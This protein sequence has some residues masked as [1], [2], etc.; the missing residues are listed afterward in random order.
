MCNFGLFSEPGQTFVFPC[1]LCLAV[2]SFVEWSVFKGVSP[3]FYFQ[4]KKHWKFFGRPSISGSN[5]LLWAM[6]LHLDYLKLNYKGTYIVWILVTILL[7][8]T[9]VLYIF[10]NL[11]TEKLQIIAHL[12]KLEDWD[13]LLWELVLRTHLLLQ[14]DFFFKVELSSWWSVSLACLIAVVDVVEV[15]GASFQKRAWLADLSY[16]PSL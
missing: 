6:A 10:K 15:L 4:K 16:W 13:F 2:L 1:L 8:K 7:L 14:E 9:T 12:C 11:G 5:M 3:E